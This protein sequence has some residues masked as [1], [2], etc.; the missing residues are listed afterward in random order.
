MCNAL[1][2]PIPPTI[3]DPVV[4]A[5]RKRQDAVKTLFLELKTTTKSSFP[6]NEADGEKTIRVFIDG[7]R[8]RLEQGWSASR[9]RFESA[10]LQRVAVF[11]GTLEKCLIFDES[12]PRGE[13]DD[14]HSLPE[15]I[16]ILYRGLSQGTGYCRLDHFSRTGKSTII[17]GSTCREYA[18]KDNEIRLWFDSDRGF[19]LKR[20]TDGDSAQLDVRYRDDGH[21]GWVLA[22]WTKALRL[23]SLG[24]DQSQEVEVRKAQFNE[25]L[26]KVEFDLRFPAGTR[27]HDLRDERD[28]LVQPDGTLRIIPEES[29]PPTEPLAP[30]P[31][32]SES[33]REPWH[34]RNRWLSYALLI[35]VAVVVCVLYALNRRRAAR[36]PTKRDNSH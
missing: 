12:A 32:A 9:Q 15:P 16:R 11:D 36:T 25:P 18:A 21:N 34:V 8:V 2:L 27:V 7:D 5:A 33:P 35:A 24:M 1:L 29:A 19:M 22:G 10:P 4:A 3:Q 30:D 17:D 26:P 20:L 23:R 14:E 28:Y 13:V 31:T 6:L